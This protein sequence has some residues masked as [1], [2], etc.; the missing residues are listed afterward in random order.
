MRKFVTPMMRQYEEIKKQYAD[1]L[2]FFRMGD[3][4]EL[5][6]EDAQIGA[7]VLSIA[8]TKRSKGR[9]G[10][11]PM[12]G[13]PCHAVDVYLSKLVKAGYKV[14]ICEQVSEPKSGELVEREVVRVVTSGTVMDERSLDKKVNNYVMALGRK[15]NMA[16]WA[17]ADLST[18]EFKL[19]ELEDINWKSKLAD[20]MVRLHP[21]ECLLSEEDYNSA[22]IL[23]LVKSAAGVNI[24]P[25]REWDDWADN[26]ET[27]LKEHFGV[28]TLSGFGV[29]SLDGGMRLGLAAATVLLN[30][31]NETQKDRVKHINKMSVWNL[32]DGLQMDRSTIM[33]LELFATI[34]E[35]EKK[36]TLLN[37]L[38]ETSTAMG[39][40]LLRRWLARPLV[41]KTEVER[42]LD[43]VEVL[44]N[45]EQLEGDVRNGL[46]QVNDL[47]RIMS[48]LSV[49]L[50]NARDLVQL[51][52]SLEHSLEILKLM[53][54]VQKFEFLLRVQDSELLQKM[55]GEVACLITEKLVDE[56]PVDVRQGKM[57]R[58]G[59]DEKLDRLNEVMC[60]GRDW[61]GEFE[62]REKERTGIQSLKVR[63]NRVFGFY[64]EVSKA[65]L[66]LVSDNYVRK[67]TL[68]NAERFITPELKEREELLLTAEEKIHQLEYEMFIKLVE[69]VLNYLEVVQRTAGVVAYLDCLVNFAWLAVRNRYCKPEM[70]ENGEFEIVDGRH[71]V[72]ERMLEGNDFV[73]NN[74][75]LNNESKQVLIITGPNMA[76]KS[77]YIRQTAVICLMAQ[78]GCF[79]PASRAR[80]SVVDRIFVRSGAAD[81]IAMGL[82]TFMVEMVETANILNNVT[83]RSLVAM[84]EVG[85]G[86]STYDGVSIAWAIVEYLAKIKNKD[87]KLS[88]PKVLFAT[89]YH[90][91]QDLANNYENVKNLQ[92]AVEELG[93]KPIFL[94]KI[95]QG[96]ASHSYGI[97]V[98]RLAGVP[99]MVIRRAVE[100]LKSLEGREINTPQFKMA[101]ESV[102][103]LSFIR[104]EAHPVMEDL[105][106]LDLDN[107]TPMEAFRKLGE[108]KG[109]MD[110]AI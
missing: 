53:V 68:V 98:A 96:G 94:H 29:G 56:P 95:V 28:K 88:R 46:K 1:C 100:V 11:I 31:L 20:E 23:K 101:L 69:V 78:M 59:I 30:Y 85:R 5:F 104:D 83:E 72:V 67:Q 55:L 63:F 70:M 73:P 32:E 108:W 79:V 60:G 47:E 84:D 99:D 48:R 18:G 45:D 90:E 8:L 12:A 6:L 80:L 77:V 86:T 107:L 52:G 61:M 37:L 102:Q 10:D 97:A 64:I 75:T 106:R 9:D 21:R 49:G 89:H 27:K 51:K 71:P 92:M 16:G 17:I 34:R 38:D 87:N 22:E 93:G 44:V 91:L 26:W 81:V 43:L 19:G 15:K 82:S 2:L 76:G 109:K 62:K 42:R 54:G 58:S 105:K 50:G 25:V 24:Y 4:Y 13:V 36:G 14:A 74:L 103:Q 7:E 110:G 33:N 66:H 41:D 57:F 3:F 65:N 39:G 40:R 35:G